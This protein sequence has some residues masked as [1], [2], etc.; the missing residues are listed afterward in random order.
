MG[1]YP[2]ISIIMPAYNSEAFIQESI[3]SVQNQIY[4]NWE[5][6]IVDDGSVDDTGNIVKKLSKEDSRII[7]IYQE[8]KKQGAARNTGLKNAKGRYIAFLDSDDLWTDDKLAK[9]IEIFQ[10][11]DVAVVFSD[12][13]FF[14][15]EANLLVEYNT[16]HGL[17]KGLEMYKLEFERN[18]IP[19]LSVMFKTE[20]I[21]KVGLQS[22]END[23]VGCED[24]DYWLR[25][26]K[27]GATFYGLPDRLFKYRVHKSSMSTNKVQMRLAEITAL[28]NNIDYSLLENKIIEDRLAPLIIQ[29]IYDLLGEKNNL[30]VKQVKRLISI[31]WRLNYI[32]VYQLLKYNL[33]KNKDLIK[34][35]LAPGHILLKFNCD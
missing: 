12:G 28:I 26:S 6:I 35:L 16:I 20:Y 11:N 4:S 25:L 13:F 24:F 1:Q 30:A 2:K 15:E 14:H 34:F 10:K 17:F 5:L 29:S 3:T 19:I 21:N 23:L 33:L 7:Y 27:Y 8:N 31:K 32:F 22:E 18:Y 9:Q